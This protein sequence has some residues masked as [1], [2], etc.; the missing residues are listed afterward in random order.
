M[1]RTPL[2]LAERNVVYCYHFA[3]AISPINGAQHYIGFAADLWARD[4]LRRAGRGARLIQ[5]AIERGIAFELVW[6]VPGSRE[7]ERQIKERKQAPRY[8]PICCAAHGRRFRAIVASAQQ[9]ALPL[10]SDDFPPV[11][12][13]GTMDW[14]EA[15]ML[16][17]MR[18]ADAGWQVERRGPLAPDWDE[19]I[20]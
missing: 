9:L 14:Y 10:E 17:R 16:Q 11:V 4:A 6:A 15:H 3:Q 20:L 8:C 7:F 12:T 19:G 18:A 2:I 5:V 1:T 13:G